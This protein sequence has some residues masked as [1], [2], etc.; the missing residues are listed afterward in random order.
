[1]GLCRACFLSPIGRILLDVPNLALKCLL[2][3]TFCPRE[4][5]LIAKVQRRSMLK[6]EVTGPRAVFVCVRFTSR[7]FLPSPKLRAAL[8]TPTGRLMEFL[9]RPV[10]TSP[11]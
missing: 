8:Q 9:S 5:V 2:D 6:T 10:I 4:L 1:M 11:A 7:A 3:E